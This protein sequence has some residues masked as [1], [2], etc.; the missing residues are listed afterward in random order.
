MPFD[1]VAGLGSF[2]SCDNGDAHRREEIVEL[3]GIRDRIR[4]GV[5]NDLLWLLQSVRDV[6]LARDWAECRRADG[7]RSVETFNLEVEEDVGDQV[8]GS[9]VGDLKLVSYVHIGTSVSLP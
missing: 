2:T 3:V 7:D 5:R 9:C 4:V 8:N 6:P 1:T